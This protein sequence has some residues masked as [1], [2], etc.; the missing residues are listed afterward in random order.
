MHQ[1]KSN[2]NIF[3]PSKSNTTKEK[4]INSVIDEVSRVKKVSH[5]VRPTILD[6]LPMKSTHSLR[7]KT[8]ID[9]KS[10][11]FWK[12]SDALSERNSLTHDSSPLKEL[13]STCS[14]HMKA[15]SMIHKIRR[16]D[17]KD[18]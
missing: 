11:I 3:Q 15:L 8:E 16:R 17:Y 10:S 12:L 1:W 2:M 7:R 5:N 4:D 13:L 14:E 9:K 18:I 6:S